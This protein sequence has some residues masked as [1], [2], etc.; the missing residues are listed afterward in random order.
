MSSACGSS[1]SAPVPGRAIDE[2]AA[3]GGT[4]WV[5][6]DRGGYRAVERCECW[7]Q[8]IDLRKYGFG[9][10]QAAALLSD[11]REQPDVA[12]QVKALRIHGPGGEQAAGLLITGSPGSGKTHL[13]AALC[14]EYILAGAA[15]SF[16]TSHAL[17][18]RLLPSHAETAGENPLGIV[19]EFAAVDFLALDDLGHEGRSSQHLLS[20]L[21]FVLSRRLDNDRA[22]AIS[23]NLSFEQLAG[24]YDQGIASRLGAYIPLALVGR[25]RRNALGLDVSDDDL[26]QRCWDDKF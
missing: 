10:A 22:T 16:T 13:L 23:T 9:K 17:F 12:A 8:R 21:H 14:R 19:E 2:C 20:H 7:K 6:V 1:S 26:P 24:V 15:A 3:C 25:D 5:P 11:F 18:Q 4:G